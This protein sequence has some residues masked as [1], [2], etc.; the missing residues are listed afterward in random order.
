MESSPLKQYNLIKKI[1]VK[2]IRTNYWRPGEN[3]IEKILKSVNKI[4]KDKDIIVLSEK[5]I[6]I[7]K[8]N[9]IDEKK[10]KPGYVAKFIAKFWMKYL[11]GYIL[12]KISGFKSESIRNLRKYPEKE[13]SKHK[14]L[15]LQ[16]AGL[17]QA[18]KQASEGGIDI[19]N[20]PYAYA[21]IPLKNSNS[22]ASQIFHE[23]KKKTGKSVIVIIVD[24]DST[25]SFRNF[26]FT[27][28]PRPIKG[29]QS[30]GGAISFI[31]GRMLKLKQRAT[32]L[33][34]IGSKLSVEDALNLAELAHHRRGYGS[35]R[36][37]WNMIDRF[38]TGLSEIT[39]Q[40]L[41]Q[42]PHYPIVLIRKVRNAP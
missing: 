27:S 10:V 1:R 3:Y 31:L 18:L 24:T 5:A 4:L 22:E 20:L 28:R 11:W 38:K 21:S 25:F 32:P 33:A 30:F 37:I 19:S 15:V 14:Q 39:W 7:A 17:L 41:D 42:V 35:G 26:H 2:T 36:T 34:V 9:L 23:I 29:I 6:S 8:G 12:G 16:Y 40:M 13:G